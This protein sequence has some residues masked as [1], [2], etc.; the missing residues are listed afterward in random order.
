MAKAQGEAAKREATEAARQK[1]AEERAKTEP[2]IRALEAENAQLHTVDEE[3]TARANV[4]DE[5]RAAEATATSTE[6][7]ERKMKRETPAGGSGVDTLQRLF[8]IDLD[9]EVA[10]AAMAAAADARAR[11]RSPKAEAHH[12]SNPF[13]TCSDGNEGDRR[14]GREL[15]G[16][17]L[18][19]AV[20]G[21]GGSN[22]TPPRSDGE[23]IPHRYRSMESTPCRAPSRTRILRGDR[24]SDEDMGISP[25]GSSSG[26]GH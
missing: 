3:E 1:V 23:G 25:G 6:D 18:G 17:V 24:D 22:G 2:G 12:N 4:E 10:Q 19:A 13:V 16:R 14:H 8:E 15:T 21:G 11:G 5:R 20:A 9:T 7:A 26:T